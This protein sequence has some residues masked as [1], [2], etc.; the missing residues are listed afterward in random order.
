MGMSPASNF[1]P[2]THISA[3]DHIPPPFSLSALQG[4]SIQSHALDLK[5]ML[6]KK[7][8][9]SLP[10]SHHF[11]GLIC[12][13]LIAIIIQMFWYNDVI[14]YAFMQEHKKSSVKTY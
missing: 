11:P 13:T 6:R 9:C 2:T 7:E 14:V 8:S 5:S 10:F 3:M 12:F 1:M 4:N